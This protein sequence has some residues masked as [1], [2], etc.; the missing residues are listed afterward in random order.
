MN[1]KTGILY[2][3]SY[4]TKDGK[5]FIK[6]LF[7]SEKGHTFSV[8]L[9]KK[10]RATIDLEDWE[11]PQMVTFDLD[12]R[13]GDVDVNFTKVES[14]ESNDGELKER[15]ILVLG[16]VASHEKTEFE[17]KNADDRL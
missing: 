16:H 11:M 2:T 9:T 13:V 7:R 6:Y 5:D 14:Y 1:L 8:T 10:M 3:K 12:E 17:H 15:D 4:K